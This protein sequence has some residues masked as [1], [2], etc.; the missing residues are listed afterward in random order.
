MALCLQAVTA[1]GEAVPLDVERRKNAKAAEAAA[2]KQAWESRKQQIALAAFIFLPHALVASFQTGPTVAEQV[3]YWVTESY[4]QLTDGKITP[5]FQ[6][7]VAA[8]FIERMCT[9]LPCLALQSVCALL[10]CP[11]RSVAGC[12]PS[13]AVASLVVVQTGARRRL[14]VG[15]HLLAVVQKVLQDAGRQADGQET[16]G[17]R[18]HH[19]LHQQ[20]HPA[21]NVRGVL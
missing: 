6:L 2:G 12:C 3:T 14:H 9:P 4:A 10:P 18:P 17:R 13:R 15:P 19:L 8:L 20:S 5:I 1:K 16:T 11:A 21:R 7:G